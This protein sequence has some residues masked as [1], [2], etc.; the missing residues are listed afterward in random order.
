MSD[1]AVRLLVV[2]G[3]A[4][5]ALGVALFA[6][7]AERRRARRAPLDLS[8]IEGR[9]LFFTDAACRR[10]DVMRRRLEE[11]GAPFTEVRY[12]REPELHRRVGIT[13]VPL[14]VVRDEEG[15]ETARL[16]GV[17]SRRRL[18]RAVG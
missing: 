1:L 18:N 7:R 9:V 12:D 13:G 16:A 14:V 4:A 3:A 11:A 8:G 6:K 10:C 17:V 5:V 15:N 2:G